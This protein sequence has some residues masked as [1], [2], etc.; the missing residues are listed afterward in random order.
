[1]VERS[2]VTDGYDLRM[3]AEDLRARFTWMAKLED[4]AD[5]NAI[6]LSEPGTMLTD[7]D[8]YVDATSPKRGRVLAMEGEQVP[9]GGVY[10]LE[11]GTVGALW[12]RIGAAIR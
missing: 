3:T 1:M 7:G 6:A 5:V 12:E 9:V 10:I 4:D 11:S 2:P 8:H